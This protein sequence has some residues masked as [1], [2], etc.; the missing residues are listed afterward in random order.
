M[1]I[2][3][4]HVSLN[5]SNIDASVAFYEKLF[6]VTATKRR[7]GYAKFDLAAPN[8]NLTMQEAPR[9]DDVVAEVEAFLLGRAR[10][11]ESA[12]VAR[13]RIWIDPGIGFGKTVTHNLALLAAL[14]RLAGL[15]YRL[16]VGASRK[17]MIRTLD[18]TAV[19]PGDRLGGSLAMALAAAR[20]GATM[21]RVHDVRETVQAL[22]VDAAV[23]G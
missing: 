10:A 5:V 1:N 8:L 17:G 11:A 2:L 21:V 19:S 16:L 18:P 6:Q 13:E 15:G 23:R 9:Y 14:D 20:A 3:K 12:G 22:T 7:P 4:P